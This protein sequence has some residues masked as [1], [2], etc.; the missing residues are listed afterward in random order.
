MYDEKSNA[1][2]WWSDVKGRLIRAEPQSGCHQSAGRLD[3]CR[4]NGER[5]G[6]WRTCA[7]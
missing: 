4:P 6:S 3:F 7:L 1:D 2:L 5:G